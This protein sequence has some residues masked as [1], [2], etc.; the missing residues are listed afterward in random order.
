MANQAQKESAARRR[1]ATRTYWPLA[2]LLL[3]AYF[4][5]RTV[6]YGRPVYPD[7]WSEYL[8]LPLLLASLYYAVT[9]LISAEEAGRRP[10]SPAL[11]LDRFEPLVVVVLV[12]LLQVVT[13]HVWPYL[14]LLLLPARLLYGMWAGF[15]D[16]PI[17]K[18]M[19]AQQAM[20][21]AAQD[22]TAAAAAEGGKGSGKGGRGADKGGRSVVQRR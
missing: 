21:K 2:V 6:V 5:A 9:G 19:Q 13:G 10:G 14:L 12:L 4:S 1:A 11:D 15:R 22:A 8:F 7:G 20:A 18:T 16:T 3:L 17:M